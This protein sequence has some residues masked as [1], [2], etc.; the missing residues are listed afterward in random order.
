MSNKK[1]I[2]ALKKVNKKV[3]KLI[4]SVEKHQRELVW[5]IAINIVTRDIEW[6]RFHK[7]DCKKTCIL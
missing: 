3:A 7:K 1:Q 6:K 5:S 2:K 4:K